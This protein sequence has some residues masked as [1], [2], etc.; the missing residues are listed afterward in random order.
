MASRRASWCPGLGSALQAHFR[1]F[2]LL[3]QGGMWAHLASSCCART[4]PPHSPAPVSAF[5]HTAQGLT[6]AWCS[7]NIYHVKRTL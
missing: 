7:I 6:P 5:L 1:P 3:S 4:V 2:S